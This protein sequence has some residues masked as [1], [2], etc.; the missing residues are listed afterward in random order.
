MWCFK[1]PFFP[2]QVLRTSKEDS[3]FNGEN[4]VSES[5][6]YEAV[7]ATFDY[8]RIDGAHDSNG[9]TEWITSI[10]PIRESLQLMV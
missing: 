4:A 9:V 1:T 6:S 2:V 8:H 3:I 10:G 5:G 7:G